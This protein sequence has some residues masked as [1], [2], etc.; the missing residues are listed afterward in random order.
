MITKKRIVLHF[1]HRLIDQPIICKLVKDYNI[2]FN[3]LRASITPKEEGVM[4]LELSGKL[5]DYNKGISYLKKLGVKIQLLSRD[6]VRN[7]SRCTH[8]GACI[9]ICPTS[10]FVLDKK[11]RKVDFISKRC[12][13]CEL[14]IKACPPHAM[15]LR[16]NV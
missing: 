7:E 8:C 11:T 10:A 2:E 13:A 12:I 1:P 5:K 16:M 4:V 15:E 9:T 6:V 14:C 3:I